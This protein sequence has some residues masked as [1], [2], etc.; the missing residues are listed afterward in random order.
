LG[1]I[2]PKPFDLPLPLNMIGEQI[3]REF[4]LLVP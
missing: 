1:D 3:A 2:E 4:D